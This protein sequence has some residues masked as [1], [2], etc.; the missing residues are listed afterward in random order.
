MRV[1]R[2]EHQKPSFT[3]KRWVG[4]CETTGFGKAGRSLELTKCPDLRNVISKL[5]YGHKLCFT[6]ISRE[7]RAAGIQDG[8]EAAGNSGSSGIWLFLLC[9]WTGLTCL[10]TW[11]ITQCLFHQSCLYLFLHAAAGVCYPA[12]L[13]QVGSWCW[14]VL[15]LSGKTSAWG[16]G[17]WAVLE[18]VTATQSLIWW[19]RAATARDLPEIYIQVLSTK[20][21]FWMLC[22]AQVVWV[23]SYSGMWSR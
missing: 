13:Y 22:P 12:H 21:Y 18:A 10:L 15:W 3:L 7:P 9:S 1:I 14:L 6:T 19:K 5:P 4:E 8:P 17:C 2:I 16:T 23:R 11:V 20:E